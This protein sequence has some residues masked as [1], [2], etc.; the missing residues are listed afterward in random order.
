MAIKNLGNFK[1]TIGKY[2]MELK[3]GDEEP[4]V[5]EFTKVLADDIIELQDLWSEYLSKESDR[6]NTKIREFIIKHLDDN[7]MFD[8]S[9]LDENSRKIFVLEYF[10]LLLEEYLVMFRIL[11][12]EQLEA[13]KAELKKLAETKG[14]QKN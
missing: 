5:L 13:F 14:D 3:R 2:D 10:G 9:G 1:R 12:R 4:I 7:K 6:T 11:T 8:G